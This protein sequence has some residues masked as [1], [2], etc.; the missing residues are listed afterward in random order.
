[1]RLPVHEKP[2]MRTL[3]LCCAVAALLAS[4]P[5][6]AEDF[7][8]EVAAPK[9]RVTLPNIPPI[10][11]ETHPLNAKQPHLRYLGSQGPYTV[12]VITPSAAQG[13]T[14]LECASATVR[15][16]AARPGFPPPAQV[17]KTRLNDHTYAAMYAVSL[18]GAVQLNAHFLSAVGGTHCVEVHASKMSTSPED[19]APWFKGFEQASID[20]K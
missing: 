15:S 19:V 6:R 1:M 5:S 12:S 9:F 17:L 11:M 20:A 3:V 13:M 16:M 8:F 14:A 10:K 7:V 4:L 18:G 2:D